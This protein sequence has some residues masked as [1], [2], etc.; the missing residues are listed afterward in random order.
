VSGRHDFVLVLLGLVF[1]D[2]M[3]GIGRL[4]LCRV[5]SLSA[6][7]VALGLP[8]W[9][10]QDILSVPLWLVADDLFD[11]PVTG[12]ELFARGNT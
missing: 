12:V 8:V 7:F 3:Y 10:R 4:R 9:L 1:Y 5:C 2:G 11:H 6:F